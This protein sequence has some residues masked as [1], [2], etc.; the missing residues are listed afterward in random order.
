[1]LLEVADQSQVA[2]ARRQAGDFAAAEGLNESRAARVAL[3]ITE[4]ATNL[5]KHAGRG[6]IVLGRYADASGSGLELLSLDKGPGI[7][8]IGRAFEDGY[9]TV[10][11]AGSGLGAIRR[12][13]DDFAI[14][15]RSGQGTAMVARVQVMA[16]GAGTT[17]I[18]GSVVEPLPGEPV[19]GDAWAFDIGD[20]KPTLLAVD[21]LGHGP[22][23]GAAAQ[24]AVLAFHERPK[25]DC[26]RLV[27]EIHIALAPTRGAAVAVAR[28]DPAERA[29]R[30]VGIGNI[31]GAVISGGVVRRMV[32]HSGTAGHVAPRVREFSYPYDGVTTVV[33]HSDGL[34]NKWDLQSYPGLAVSHPSLIAGVLFRDF[35]CER[36][37]A[38]IVVMQV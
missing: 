27:E 26:S 18:L 21:G 17:A 11:S 30:F 5:I 35:R 31:A 22:A 10:G 1:M 29:V 32:S 6:V 2:A 36:D 3:L 13:A 38:S 4:M 12:Q 25:E 19:C 8:D 37:D 14:F 34:S 23:A 15:S 7:V 24:V 9:S 33:L 16:A 20:G 28:L